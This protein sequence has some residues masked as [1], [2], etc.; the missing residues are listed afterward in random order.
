[1]IVDE[2]WKLRAAFRS[3]LPAMERHSS[4]YVNRSP[5]HQT[6]SPRQIGV[7]PVRKKVLVKDLPVQ[8]SIVEGL[9][10]IERS[11][12]TGPEDVFRL[13]VLAEIRLIRTTIEM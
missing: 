3:H 10:A 9:H 11:G 5:A 8:R 13:V 4:G 7:F 6:A 1:M 2:R 12:P